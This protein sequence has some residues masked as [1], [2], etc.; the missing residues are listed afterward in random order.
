MKKQEKGFTVFQSSVNLGPF[1]PATNKSDIFPSLSLSVFLSFFSPSLLPFSSPHAAHQ[2]MLSPGVLAT[3]SAF[4]RPCRKSVSAPYPSHYLPNNT[5]CHC[6]HK[7]GVF[8]C[9]LLDSTA[10]GS[11]L[12]RSNDRPSEWMPASLSLFLLYVCLCASA[13][14]SM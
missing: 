10:S 13:C 2:E 12:R 1:F 14:P 8:H 7:P 6:L 11:S 9:V 5:N 4:I 3:Q